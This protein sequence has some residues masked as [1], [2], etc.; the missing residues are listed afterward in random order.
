MK[1]TRIK[2]LRSI[3]CFICIC[4]MVLFSTGF[5]VH[6]YPGRE[7]ITREGMKILPVSRDF[8]NYFI[9]QSIEDVTNIVIGDFVGADKLFCLII[10]KNSDGK[11]DK[12]V[13]YAPENKKYSYP[14]KPTSSFFSNLE[15]MKKQ[16]IEGDIFRNNYAFKMKSLLSLQELLKGGKDIFKH[17]TGW[18]VKFYD[19]DLPT[20]TMYEFYFSKNINGRY[21]LV[22]KTNYYKIFRTKI[23][24]VV[25]F[26]VYCRNSKDPFIAETVESLLKMVP[27][28]DMP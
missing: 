25:Y 13:E 3:I 1:N 20:T 15:E 5:Q 8:R 14:L 7:L 19:P 26:S 27:N 4:S 21:D 2:F 22:F 28:S 16:I 6:D 24:P 18:S 17:K 9:I 11:I 10:D 12:V 23:H